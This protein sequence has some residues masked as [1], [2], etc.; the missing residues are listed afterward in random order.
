MGPATPSPAQ[1]ISPV[2]HLPDPVADAGRPG[3]GDAAPGA[4]AAALG[5]QVLDG[6]HDMVGLLVLLLLGGDHG[7]GAGDQKRAAAGRMVRP[8]N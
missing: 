8:P 5:R 3:G 4:V 6:G 1:P 2:Q 7:G